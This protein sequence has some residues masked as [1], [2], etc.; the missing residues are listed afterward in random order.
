METRELAELWRQL[1]DSRFIAMEERVLAAITGLQKDVAA[2]IAALR[3]D[4]E[5][6]FEALDKKLDT[7]LSDAAKERK[8]MTEQ[9]HKQDLQIER[10]EERLDS[11]ENE[12]GRWKWFVGIVLGAIP[13]II[14]IVTIIKLF[15]N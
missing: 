4:M 14:G 5:Y 6:R 7:G 9:N 13:V 12:V 8:A 15:S 11:V 2:E 1:L 10:H 3:Q